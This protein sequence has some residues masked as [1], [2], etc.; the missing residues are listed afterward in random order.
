MIRR[1]APGWPMWVF[2]GAFLPLLVVLGFWQ[3]ERAEEKREMQARI[4]QGRAQTP[5]S[6]TELAT[7]EDVAWRRIRLKG[8]FDVEH[9]WILDNRTRSG[10]AGVEVLQPFYD[11]LSGQW[12][13]VNRGWLPW[14]D[15][16]QRPIVETP[17]ETVTLTVEALPEPGRGF[18]LPDGADRPGWPK[19]IV[20]VDPSRLYEQLDLDGPGWIARVTDGGP[21]ALRLEWPG[22][23]MTSAKHIGYAVQWFALAA[24]LLVLFIWAGLRPD[25][26][27]TIPHGKS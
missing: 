5:S 14:R 17:E 4:D 15:R 6:L 7:G 12:V 27:G 9:A 11:E 26:E 24:A 21:G 22:L 16:S 2:V 10:R 3:L 20:R 1:F 13:I 25:S 18:E 23:P 8:Q 19:L